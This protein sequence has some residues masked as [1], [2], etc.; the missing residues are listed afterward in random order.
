VFL[1]GW[2]NFVESFH[3]AYADTAKLHQIRKAA[4]P[5]F[6]GEPPTSVFGGWNLMLSRYSMHK[7]ETLEFMQF[8]QTKEAQIIMYEMGGFLPTSRDVYEDSVYMRK[9]PDLAY[10][11][12]LLQRG[13]H[14]PSL[15]DYTR[16]SD[17]LSYYVHRAITRE[18]PVGEALERASTMIRSNQVLIK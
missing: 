6:P 8:T 17:I 10:Y 3:N 15:V 4:L 7:A 1:R 9:H 5:H 16:I 18:I 12:T 11:Y 13:F 2:P 14:R